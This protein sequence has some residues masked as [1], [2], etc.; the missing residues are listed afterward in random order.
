MYFIIGCF[1]CV[2]YDSAKPRVIILW[3]SLNPRSRTF[4]K[5][6]QHNPRDNELREIATTCNTRNITKYRSPIEYI[7]KLTYADVK[8][9]NTNLR[10][11][12]VNNTIEQSI[13]HEKPMLNCNL[14]IFDGRDNSKS[15]TEVEKLATLAFSSMDSTT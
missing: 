7:N 2:T 1:R 5:S 10:K 13:Q 15:R 4:K 12:F 3:E 8:I 9:R 11:D 6:S 14:R